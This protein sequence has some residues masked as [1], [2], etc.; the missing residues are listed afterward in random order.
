MFAG[1]DATNLISKAC[2]TRAAV[3]EAFGMCGYSKRTKCLVISGGLEVHAFGQPSVPLLYRVHRDGARMGAPN[4]QADTV[5]ELP[6]VWSLRSSSEPSSSRAPRLKR[7]Y[8][9]MASSAD[10]SRTKATH[11]Y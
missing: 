9:H 8:L 6:P 3:A 2:P 7:S 1:V 4:F 5:S 10:Y 11:H